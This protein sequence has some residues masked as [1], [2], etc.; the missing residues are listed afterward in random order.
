MVW[1]SHEHK[2]CS[3]TLEPFHQLVLNQSLIESFLELSLYG[4][5]MTEAVWECHWSG[6]ARDACKSFYCDD[7]R[8]AT[9]NVYCQ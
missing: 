4:Q 9:H 7:Q 2:D 5:R 8:K 3:N 1:H 6:S